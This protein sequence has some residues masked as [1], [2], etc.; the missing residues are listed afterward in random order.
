MVLKGF[1]F[2]FT[3]SF[4][5]VFVHPLDYGPCSAGST[6]VSLGQKSTFQP[7]GLG[8]VHFHLL[9]VFTCFSQYQIPVLPKLLRSW[10]PS[11]PCLSGLGLNRD[12]SNS[13][14]WRSI[15]NS[16]DHT[17]IT[18]LYYPFDS[19]FTI[20][21]T[22]KLEKSS[23]FLHV[24]IIV[25]S[26]ARNMAQEVQFCDC[27]GL[28]GTWNTA[29]LTHTHTNKPWGWKQQ[30]VLLPVLRDH[31]S[32]GGWECTGLENLFCKHCVGNTDF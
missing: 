21:K 6:I 13:R 20:G 7:P 26:R 25:S 22:S 27:S 16:R 28:N 4:V 29:H 31:E 19:P 23:T 12:Y 1:A 30:V 17:L 3:Y 14:A 8:S 11:W 5:C 18:S 10:T 15:I 24:T 9:E 32:P 2:S